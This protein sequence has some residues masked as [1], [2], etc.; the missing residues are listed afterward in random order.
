MIGDI[1]ASIMRN[2]LLVLAIGAL[3]LLNSAVWA[4]DE[5]ATPSCPTSA[6]SDAPILASPATADGNAPADRARP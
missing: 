3:V 4:D 1:L 5:V 6:S 2:T